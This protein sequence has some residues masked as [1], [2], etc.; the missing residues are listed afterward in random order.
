M[1]M[2]SAKAKGKIIVPFCPANPY[3]PQAG[4]KKTT[5]NHQKNET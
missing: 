5:L 3:F 1:R 2:N 4:Q